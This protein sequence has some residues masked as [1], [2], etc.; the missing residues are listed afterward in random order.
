[1]RTPILKI[2][3]KKNVAIEIANQSN[4]PLNE[5]MLRDVV[6]YSISFLKAHPE[7]DVNILLV[8]EDEMEGLNSRWLN[9]SGPTDVISFPM[10]ELAPGFDVPKPE[11]GILGDIVL[12][13]S[14]AENQAKS[15]GH[16]LS[17]EL[18]ILTIHA[19]LHLVGYDHAEPLDEKEMF[20]LQSKILCEFRSG[21]VWD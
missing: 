17:K 13:P 20:A 14:V 8:N 2:V 11:K 12:C 1:M 16:S 4:F 21:A 18:Q 3:E 10:D 7:S 19:M 5:N 15:A 6:G 9:K